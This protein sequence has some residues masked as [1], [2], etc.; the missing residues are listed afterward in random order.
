[1][2]SIVQIIGAVYFHVV[3]GSRVPA[4]L[5]FVRI[6]FFDNRQGWLARSHEILTCTVWAPAHSKT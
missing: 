5:C 6:Q 3:K 4:F 2:R 1:M